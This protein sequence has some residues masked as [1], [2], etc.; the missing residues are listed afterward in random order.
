MLAWAVRTAQRGCR[1]GQSGMWLHSRRILLH[2]SSTFSSLQSHLKIHLQ[3]EAAH[4]LQEVTLAETVFRC[5]K[6]GSE[7]VAR[8]QAY[9]K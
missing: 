3:D 9:V 1:T 4:V 7:E 6:H 5:V 8:P 2:V